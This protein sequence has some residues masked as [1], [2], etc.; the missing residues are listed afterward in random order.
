M[1]RI[2]VKLKHIVVILTFETSFSQTGDL[3]LTISHYLQT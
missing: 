2:E 3:Q 1:N